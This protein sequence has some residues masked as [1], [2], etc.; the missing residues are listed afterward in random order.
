MVLIAVV[1]MTLAL[2]LYIAAYLLATKH[3]IW[4]IAAACTAFGLD[5]YATYLME[6]K[7]IIVV[8]SGRSFLY[9]HIIVSVVALL[10]FIAL[11]TVGTLRERKPHIFIAKYLF[12]PIWITSYFSGMFLIISS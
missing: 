8:T 3:R 7:Q 6:T 9:F 2:V 1:S 4:H 10:A 5:L 12:F 11:A